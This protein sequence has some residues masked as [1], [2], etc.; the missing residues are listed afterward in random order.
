MEP[1]ALSLLAKNFNIHWLCVCVACFFIKD[2][3]KGRGGQEEKTLKVKS[4]VTNR[5]GRSLAHHLLKPNPF[6]LIN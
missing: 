6:F 3:E 4:R 2:N 1:F 5:G